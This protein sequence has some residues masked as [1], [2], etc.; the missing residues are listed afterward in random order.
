MT[1]KVKDLMIKVGPAAP[2]VAQGWCGFCTHGDS[3]GA[4]TCTCSFGCTHCSAG[5]SVGFPGDIVS[6]PPEE[7]GALKAQLKRQL[8][9]VEA[10]EKQLEPQT[11]EDVQALETQLKGAL[12][13]LERFKKELGNK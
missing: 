11:L 5:S 3:C 6:R 10:A 4:C 7:L 1:F 2:G 8:A 9:L 13:E 12:A